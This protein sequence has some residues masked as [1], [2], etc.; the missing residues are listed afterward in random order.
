MCSLA[1]QTLTRDYI[2]IILTL[3]SLFILEPTKVRPVLAPPI[4]DA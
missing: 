3:L 2:K 1:G 4:Y